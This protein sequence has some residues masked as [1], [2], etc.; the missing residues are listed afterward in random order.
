MEALSMF[1]LFLLG[2]LAEGVA[3]TISIDNDGYCKFLS[4]HI[5]KN[6]LQ[7]S[8]ELRG[9][10]HTSN[11]EPGR[12]QSKQSTIQN[13]FKLYCPEHSLFNKLFL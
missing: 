9:T 7:L 11:H 8:L 2:R 10:Q 6:S 5:Q 3:S 1:T 4:A 13:G 12:Q